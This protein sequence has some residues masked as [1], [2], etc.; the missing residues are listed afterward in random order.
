VD[1]PGCQSIARSGE[2]ASSKRLAFLADFQTRAHPNYQKAVSMVHQ[3]NIGQIVSAEASYQTGPVGKNVDDALRADPA[4]S[5]LRLRAWVTDRVLSG[6]IITEQN[7]HALDMASWALNAE[8]VKAYGAGGKKRSF[9]GNCWDHFACVFYYPNDILLSFSSKQCGRFWDDIMC[10]VY[11]TDGTLDMHYAGDVQV[12]CDDMY[13]GGKLVDL[14]ADGAVRNIATFHES[15]RKGDFSNSTVAPSVRS[16]MLAI[17]G[18][19]AAYK[20]G[21]VTWAE[22]IKAGE[23]LE[24]ATAGLKS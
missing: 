18:R 16:N 1:V 19:T 21:E 5:E 3:G 17:L 4:N 2:L 13:N 8:P 6:D 14:Y 24:F 23:R 22:I 10:R 11:G 20:N 9:V 7:I 12:H 15:I